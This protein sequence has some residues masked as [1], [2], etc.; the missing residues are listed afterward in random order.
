M[1]DSPPCLVSVG[2]SEFGGTATT[3]Q[4]SPDQ[5]ERAEGQVEVSTHAAAE[6]PADYF[7]F[8]HTSVYVWEEIKKYS[9]RRENNE[10]L[11]QSSYDILANTSVCQ[12][13]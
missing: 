5:A 3:T 13:E 4:E 11:I 6:S 12:S 9:H 1:F 8:Y 2:S 7:S 10:R